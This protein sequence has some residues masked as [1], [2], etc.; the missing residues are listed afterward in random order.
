MLSFWVT[1]CGPM[2]ICFIVSNW[3]RPRGFASASCRA[4]EDIVQ[5]QIRA[6][7]QLRNLLRW[8]DP[9]MLHL[10]PGVDEI[11]F[12][13]LMELAPQPEAVHELERFAFKQTCS[14]SVETSRVHRL[15]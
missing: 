4:E 14:R 8:Y 11:W 2:G 13:D 12:W 5:E 7:N 6:G 1:L 15:P 3:M 10:C 9:Q